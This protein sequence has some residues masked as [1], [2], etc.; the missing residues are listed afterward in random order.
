MCDAVY[1]YNEF[2]TFFDPELE[3]EIIITMRA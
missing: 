2:E 3:P 1:Q